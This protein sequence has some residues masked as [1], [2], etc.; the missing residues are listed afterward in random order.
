MM[1][2]S[3]G[4]LDTWGPQVDDETLTVQFSKAGSHSEHKPITFGFTLNVHPLRNSEL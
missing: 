3:I 4:G 1:L 2:L